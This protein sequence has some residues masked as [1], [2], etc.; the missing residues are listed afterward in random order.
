M[1]KKEPPLLDRSPPFDPIAEAGV[2]G[3]V[4]L[5]PSCFAEISAIVGH[6]DFYDFAHTVIFRAIENLFAVHQ[7]VDAVLVRDS[8]IKA[9]SFEIA[10]GSAYL[11]KLINSVPNAAHAV[12]YAEIVAAKSLARRVIEQATSLLTV[13]Y[14]ERTEPEELLA[15]MSEATSAMAGKS[16]LKSK[17]IGE[18]AA[19]VVTELRANLNNPLHTVCMTGIPA[20]DTVM[21]PLVR[22]ELIVLAARPG[23]GKTAAGMQMAMHAADQNKRVLFVSLEMHGSELA[24][25][26]ICRIADINSRRVREGG[27]S[28]ESID[29]LDAAAKTI[30]PT[31]V[32]VWSPP[33]GTLSQIQ[34]LARHLHAKEPLSLVVVDYITKVAAGPSEHRMQREE[35]VGRVT[36]GLRALAKELDIPVVALAQLNRAADGQ[37]PTLAMLRESGQIEQEANVVIGL[38]SN[39]TADDKGDPFTV[40]AIILKHRAGVK[41]R[42]NL[43][44][45]PVETRFGD[46]VTGT[47]PEPKRARRQPRSNSTL[48]DYQRNF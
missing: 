9:G 38:H 41:G 3:S 16:S 23:I 22:K 39:E 26:V 30:E 31:P 17:T 47:P 5:L 37:E 33:F 13:A 4:F 8:L 20:L 11:S 6:E 28:L 34:G 25:R 15:K 32:I 10:G 2:I 45:H 1:K 35:R 43:T 27:L 7:R 14:D 36:E 19:D 18:H 21:G 29:A 40:T 48:N 12:Y 42:V 24:T 46:C 44:F